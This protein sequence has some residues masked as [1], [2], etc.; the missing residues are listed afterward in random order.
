M[1]FRVVLIALLAASASLPAI[2]ATTTKPAA[3][4]TMAAMAPAKG[5]PATGVVCKVVKSGAYVH[6]QALNTGTAVVPKGDTFTFTIVGPKK[7]TTK[8]VTFKSDLA[9]GKAR[10]ATTAIKASSVVSCTPAS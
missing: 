2:A 8:T 9:P 4:T 5:T 10:N 3:M 1:S 7:S 6:I